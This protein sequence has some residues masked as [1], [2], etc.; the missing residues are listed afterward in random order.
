MSEDLQCP[1]DHVKVNENKVRVVALL[2]L[3]L[4]AGFLLTGYNFIILLLLV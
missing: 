4:G 1:I 3:L 2:V